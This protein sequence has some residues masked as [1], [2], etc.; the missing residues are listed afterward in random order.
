MFSQP[1]KKAPAKKNN[2]FPQNKEIASGLII[3]RRDREGLRFLLLYHGNGYWNFPKG[4]IEPAEKSFAAALREVREETGLRSTDLRL[5]KNYKTYERF[6]FYRHRRKIS[7]TVIL[8]LAE[9]KVRLIKISDEHVGYAWF[10]FSETKKILAKYKENL[11]IINN[12]HLFLKKRFRKKT[13]K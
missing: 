9:T 11:N 5:V 12:V 3:F 4:K 1:R 2:Y 6:C 8:Y 10:S 13:K 7:K